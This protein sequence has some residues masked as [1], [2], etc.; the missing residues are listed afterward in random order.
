MEN[1]TDYG[2]KAFIAGI[3]GN[4]FLTIFNIVIGLMSGSYALISEGAHTLSDITT[5]VI[6]YIGFVIAKKPADKEHPL[7][8]GRAEAIAGLIIV[9]FLTMVSYEILRGAIEK[10]ISHELLTPPGYLAAVMAFIGIIV[11]L[12]ISKYIISIGK[13]INSPAIIANGEHQKVDFFSSIAILIGVLISRIGLPILDPIIGLVIGCVIL[14]TAYNVGRDNINNIMGKIPSSDL[15]EEVK[16]IAM[17]NDKVLGVHNI[18]IDYLGAYAVASLHIEIEPNM[19]LTE[20][21]KIAHEVQDDI[22]DKITIIKSITAHSCP[23]GIKYNHEQE[24]DK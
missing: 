15:L 3:V 1:R 24:I 17:K 19:T 22:L 6:A 16:K 7:G 14:K 12:S 23:Y 8:H 9:L 13:K 4:S 21:H 11:N 18:K 5:T 10:L 2:K 20:S